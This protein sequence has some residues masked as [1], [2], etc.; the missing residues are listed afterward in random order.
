LDRERV[1]R[2]RGK[3]GTEREMC[4]TYHMFSSRRRYESFMVGLSSSIM[5]GWCL[6]RS[7]NALNFSGVMTS[8]RASRIE[9]VSEPVFSESRRRIWKTYT[10]IEKVRN[11]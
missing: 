7:A 8:L 6:W 11:K 4:D 3:G 1:A 9:P 5:E 10:Y 2:D